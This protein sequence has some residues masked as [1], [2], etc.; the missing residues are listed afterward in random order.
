MKIIL[1]HNTT[2]SQMMGLIFV[3]K[4]N[5]I[6]AT[7]FIYNSPFC[8]SDKYVNM[9]ANNSAINLRRINNKTV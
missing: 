1:M 8:A 3:T 7:F 9:L 2:D 6:I 5:K 4:N